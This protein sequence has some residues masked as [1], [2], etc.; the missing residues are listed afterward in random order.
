[1]EKPETPLPISLIVPANSWP[2]V[3]GIFSPVMGWGEVGQ[4][5]VVGRCKLDCSYLVRRA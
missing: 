4:K 5:L 1:M 2:I 3:M